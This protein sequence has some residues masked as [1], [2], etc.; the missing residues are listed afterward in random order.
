MTHTSR[1][2]HTVL[3][4]SV[5][6]NMGSE[7]PKYLNT[8]EGRFKSTMGGIWVGYTGRAPWFNIPCPEQLDQKTQK[9]DTF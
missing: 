7:L 4:G 2:P 1:G 5:L 6:V 3:V 9:P 8:E